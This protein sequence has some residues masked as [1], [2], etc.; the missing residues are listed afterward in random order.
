MCGGR[1]TNTKWSDFF[2]MVNNKATKWYNSSHI[3]VPAPR[4][5][6]K[7]ILKL[8][9]VVNSRLDPHSLLTH[10]TFIQVGE[11]GQSELRFASWLSGG[12]SDLPFTSRIFLASW[13]AN[14]FMDKT[15]KL[16]LSC[17]P[18]T[19][20]GASVVRKLCKSHLSTGV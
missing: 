11:E 15:F 18:P 7:T 16:F 9:Y 2:L 6:H 3:I 17:W 19:N 5:L 20:H 1:I 10:L 13:I 12:L 8:I 4:K 14:Y